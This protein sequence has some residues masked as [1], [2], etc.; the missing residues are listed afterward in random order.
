MKKEDT[1]TVIKQDSPMEAGLKV[2]VPKAI[3]EK[4]G[5]RSWQTIDTA[6]LKRIQAERAKARA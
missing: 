5:L 1:I 4:L 3:A 2:A 6:M